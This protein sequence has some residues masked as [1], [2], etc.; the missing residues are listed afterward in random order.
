V[1]LDDLVGINAGPADYEMKMRGFKNQGG[2]KQGNKNFTT[3]WN[4]GTRQCIQMVVKEGQV[5]W[6]EISPKGIASRAIG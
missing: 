1:S 6:I 2:Y 5:K 4:E 3:W